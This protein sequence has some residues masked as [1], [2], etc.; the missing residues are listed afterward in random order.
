MSNFLKTKLIIILWSVVILTLIPLFKSNFNAEVSFYRWKQLTWDDFQ[1][2]VKPFTHWAAG[3]SSSVYVEFD[4]TESKYVAYAAMNEQRSWK[5]ASSVDSDY[6]LN[7]EQYHFNITEYF[8]RKLNRIINEENI[9][10]EDEVLSKLSAIRIELN[11]M[12]DKYD[13]ECDHSLIKDVQRKWEYK[14]D[15]LLSS[16]EPDSGVFIDY[17]SGGMVH[18]P[19]EFEFDNGINE[20][21]SAY[22][23]YKLKKYDMDLN[24]ISFQYSTVSPES[25]TQNLVEYYS[26][27]SLQ[28]VD[29][30]IDSLK[31]DYQ[32]DVEIFDSLLIK[33]S[34]HSWII[35]DEYLYAV[36]ASFPEDSTKTAY[37]NIASSFI[38]SFKIIDTRQYWLDKFVNTNQVN[39]Q[40]KI[41]AKPI[42]KTND[43]N[44]NSGCISLGES[45]LN[46]FHGKPIFNDDGDLLIPFNILAHSDSLVEEGMLYYNKNIYFFE[47]EAAQLLFY[48]PG[49]D[50]NKDNLSVDFGYLLKQDSI[51]ECYKF[52]NQYLSID[53][54]ERNHGRLLNQ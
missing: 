33:T 29:F 42:E 52:Y 24:M 43:E 14:V 6:I 45:S 16:F 12:Q 40:T 11:A 44:K 32:A 53:V 5:K 27:D 28:I 7:H 8:A 34:F 22:R 20:N 51:N 31:Y 37:R 18:M 47:N 4:S 1:G 19:S 49:Q 30:K 38:N 17:Y 23:M 36:R 39:K 48:I 54:D 10:S 3:I 25:M 21:G 41:E 15:S 13:A 2:S 26:D 46:G 50:I 35:H 9:T